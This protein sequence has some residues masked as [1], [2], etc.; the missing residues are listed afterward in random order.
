[1]LNTLQTG[2]GERKA[3]GAISKKQ[4]Q[5]PK[6]QCMLMSLEDFLFIILAISGMFHK[7]SIIAA[8]SATFS[9]DSPGITTKYNDGL[10]L[11]T[12][13]NIDYGD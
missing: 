7:G 8:I 13:I 2:S 3:S 5:T 12:V 10:Y 9:I 11:I 1:M 4:I 6:A